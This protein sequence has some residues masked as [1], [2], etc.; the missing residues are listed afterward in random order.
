MQFL[1]RWV[2]SMAVLISVCSVLAPGAQPSLS[3]YVVGDL[4]RVRPGDA[5]QSTA[6]AVVAAARNEYAPFQIIVHA[7]AAG[8]KGVNAAASALK[9]NRG[10]G[11]PATQISLFREHYVEVKQ[12]SP[13]S[14]GEL[15]WYPDA[16][17][18]F[19]DPSTGK[20]PL[21]AR[22]PAAPFDV[23]PNS[24]QPLWVDV[25]VPKDIVPGDYDG[26]VTI[27]ALNEKPVKVPVH[28]SVWNFTLPDAPSMR[29]HFG[30][31]DVNPLVSRPPK[32]AAWQS[33][34]EKGQRELQVAYAELVA[35]HHLCPPVPPFLMP[36]V[37]ADGTIDPKPTHAGFRQWIE[38]FH[39]TGLPI[40]F[41]GM[42]GRG[43]RGDPLGADRERNTRYL[44]SMFAY[45]KANNWDKLA[46]IYVVDEP[47]T[48]EAYDEV[49][50]RAK[51]VHEVTPGLKVLCTEQ[52]KPQ[53]PAWGSLVGSVDIWSPIW[54]EFQ[55][56]L[57]KERLAAGEELWSYTALCQGR[58]RDTP[59]WQLDFPLLNYRIPI[60]ISWRYGITGLLYWSTT[61]WMTTKD[62]WTDPLT[63]RNYNLEG[64]L[65]Y[66]GVDAGVQGVVSSIR[67]K[68]IREGLEDYEYFKVLADRRGKTAADEVVTRIA[69]SWYDWDGNPGDLLKARAEIAARILAK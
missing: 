43:W 38:R 53:N 15:G 60:W 21:Q 66:P 4:E 10:K 11:I 44:Q 26:A 12:L 61:C 14:K 29:T 6:A 54:V 27:T 35:A 30:D 48:K 65:V 64:S 68:Q 69:Q 59:F 36:K 56:D 39:I 19:V 3:V 22:F 33:L 67:L 55:E 32:I 17:I 23:S 7:G 42:D 62:V 13:K 31:A 41:L 16:L 2:L 51:F 9:G 40:R 34:D 58:D 5:P 24:N 46:Y 57:A 37:N 63:Y 18:P 49:R 8:L 20:P 47:N 50:A 28:L 52:I 1:A 45:L 25:L